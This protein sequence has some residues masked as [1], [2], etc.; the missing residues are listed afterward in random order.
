MSTDTPETAAHP[1]DTPD[2][3]PPWPGP[4]ARPEPRPVRFWSVPHLSGPDL[5][6]VLAER[7][8]E[9]PVGPI[10]LPRGA[11]HAWLITRHEDA[12][13]VTGDAH[14]GRRP[15]TGHDD[16]RTPPHFVPLDAA[17]GPAD[18]PAPERLRRPLAE[19]FSAPALAR[20]GERARRIMDD[21]VDAMLRA[22]GPADLTERIN[23]PLASAVVGGITGVPAHD[24]PLTDR[25]TGILLT[26]THRAPRDRARAGID[27]YFTGVLARRRTKGDDLVA[28][29]ARAV[30]ADE[31]TS[32]EAVAA[33]VLVQISATHAVTAH[34]ATLLHALLTHPG[35]MARLRAEP[36]LLPGAVE[37]LLCLVP[38]R[39][40]VR[41]ARIAAED[42]T[43]RGVRI[44]AGEAVYVPYPTDDGAPDP[45]PHHLIGPVL[46][47]LGS[48]A[49][50][51]C[52]L[53]R[54]PRL[55][56]AVPPDAPRPRRG[57]LLRGPEALPVLW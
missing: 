9:D 5:D 47:R 3:G 16:T 56:L 50:G 1:R 26:A 10:E 36:G 11:G 24:R 42:V 34:G 54:L 37:E 25:W 7:P 22:G 55:R 19:A 46:A 44:R 33:A 48:T 21:L 18:P 29:L 2:T 51:A 52:L 15:R 57:G 28:V 4:A 30:E 40:R 17:L 39:E 43:V 23:G 6:P 35:H 31:L 13:L 14:P 20:G 53:D 49:M 12:A 41:L 45:G 8:R 38:Y 32:E 27:A